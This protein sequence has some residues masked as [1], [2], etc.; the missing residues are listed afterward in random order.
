MNGSICIFTSSG[1][2]GGTT[3]LLYTIFLIVNA[4]LGAGLLNFPSAFVAAGGVG[5]AL[6][7][8]SVLLVFI[9]GALVILAYCADMVSNRG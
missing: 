6:V 2:D 4:A 5:T 3:G 7:V 1:P 9:L 8:Q